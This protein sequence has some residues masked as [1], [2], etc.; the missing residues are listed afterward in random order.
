MRR[1]GL[2]ALLCLNLFVQA[3]EHDHIYRDAEEVCTLCFLVSVL[4]VVK[5]GVLLDVKSGSSTLRLR[6]STA[7]RLPL[8]YRL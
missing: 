8:F 3:D 1:V 2:V 7:I 5:P 4:S 6:S